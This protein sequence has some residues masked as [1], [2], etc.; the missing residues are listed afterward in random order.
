MRYAALGDS[1]TEGVGDVRKDGSVRGWADLVAKRIAKSQPLDYLNLAVRGRQ[2]API[3]SDQLDAALAMSPDLMTFC[4]GGNDLLA[5]RP[6][7]GRLRETTESVIV[8]TQRAGVRLVMLSNADPTAH[9]P[10]GRAIRRNAA[11]LHAMVCELVDGYD[12][13]LVDTFADA[14]LQRAAYW[15]ADRIHLNR[16]GHRRVAASVLA[17][18]G[19]PAPAKWTTVAPGPDPA[20]GRF[21]AAAF[22]ARQ[23][24]LVARDRL[25]RRASGDGR[26]AKHVD[27]QRLPAVS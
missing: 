9:L 14:E 10:M 15:S 19:Y 21:D 16:H 8:R 1:F 2:L 6:N 20:P 25:L 3:A 17:H 4:G 11:A 12:V 24:P 13:E 7:L 23:L 18:L 26:R 27:W 5:L 22:G